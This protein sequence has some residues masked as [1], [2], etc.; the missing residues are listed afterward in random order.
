MFKVTAAGKPVDYT[1]FFVDPHWWLFCLLIVT[2]NFLLLALDPLPQL[3][4]GDSGSYLWTAL[5]GWIPPDRSFLYGYLI[6]WSSLW[7]GS[8][9]SLLIL[10]AFLGAIT[11]I[12]VA[13]VC[14]W[15]FGLSSGLSYLFGVL[16][17]LDPLELVWHRYVMTE[18]VSLFVYAFVLLFSFLYL[19]QKRL[20]QLAVV[21]ILS[22]LLISFRMSYL[23]VVQISTFLLPLIAFL[24]EIRTAFW[25]RSSI[26]LKASGLR[27]VGL[28]LVFSILLMF[29]LHQ[30][31]R[32][33]NGRF[34]GREP[35]FLHNSGLS[36]LTTWAPIL[37]PTDSPDSRLA[38]LIAK[39][40]EFR[41]NDVWS[42]D[43]QLYSPG[44][45]VARWKQ[46]EP[47]AAVS[48]QVAKQTALNALLRRP[49]DVLS[50]GAKTFLHY[51]NFKH[52]R[53][54]AKVELGKA[55]NNWPKTKEWNIGARFHLQ[56][57]PAREAKTYTL[58]QRH[59]LNSQPYYY[60]VLLSPFVCLGLMFFMHQ[61]LVFLLFIHSS[62][63]FGTVTI[64]SKEASVRY[65]QPMSLI[66]I[67]I[68][69]A[70]VKAVIDRRSQ[71]TSVRGHHHIHFGRRYPQPPDSCAIQE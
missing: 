28:H 47:N 49:L 43:S 59:F 62:V 24:P 8:L 51:W 30:G 63:L 70:L 37:K 45:L 68:F 13:I 38:E 67:L 57:P 23:L 71:P 52:I 60:V 34:A 17:M 27:S 42:R 50:L 69:A 20:W 36:V 2:L 41:L 64:L 48:N 39:G 53:R 22:V 44:G 26:F 32:K 12:L 15:I 11:A 29:V 54:Q 46:I 5:S 40:N 25:Q 6:R 16:C 3:F 56:P 7:T 1:R 66:T 10:Q 55:R 31:Y 19:K 33:L 58:S 65:L 61:G 18:T 9:T 21:Q 35:A 4:M 14:R